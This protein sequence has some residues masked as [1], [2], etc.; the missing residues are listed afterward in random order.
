MEP[1]HSSTDGTARS[2]SSADWYFP[3]LLV[4]ALLIL[5]A[6]AGR[7]SHQPPPGQASATAA[8]TPSPQPKGQTV[9]LT[10]DFGNG[11][12]KEFAALPWH[13]EM[14]VAAVLETAQRFRPGIQFT[15]V[16]RGETGFLSALDGLAN[17]GAGGRNWLYRVDG[18]HAH[19]SFCLE[20]LQAGMH[21]L[22]SFTNQQY[23]ADGAIK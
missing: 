11:A 9:S 4:I 1:K 14:T 2:G 20:K 10:I 15:Q 18:R 21:V 22:W 23:N 19:Q 7:L 16:G 12:T 17:E 5:L 8:W 3:L 13:A 6:F